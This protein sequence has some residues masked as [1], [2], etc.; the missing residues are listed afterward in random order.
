MTNDPVRRTRLI[1]GILISVLALIAGGCLIAASLGIYLSGG[2]QIYTPEKVA[3]AFRAIALWIYLFLAAVLSGFVLDFFLPVSGKKAR[4]EKNLAATLERLLSK[5]D[6]SSCDPALKT[7]IEALEKGR[8]RDKIITLTVLGVC[9]VGFLCYGANPAN[10]HQSE[11]N[12]SMAKATVILLCCL[13]PA[14]GCALGTHFRGKA[15][16]Q[17]QIELVKQLPAGDP[18]AP[19]PAA[20]RRNWLSILRWALVCIAVAVLLYGFCTGGTA[21][22]LTKAKNIC[23]ECVGLG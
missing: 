14:F 10:F 18:V 5:R 6:L 19:A 12:A 7:Q 16:L 8:T 21:D 20:S 9:S 17:A 2:E 3:D 22:V 11:I 23:T 13:A 15:S 4:A 1:F